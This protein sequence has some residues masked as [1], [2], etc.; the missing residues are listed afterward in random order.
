MNFNKFF[1]LAASKGITASQIQISKSSSTSV[2]LFK[3]EIESFKIS[4]SQS[5]IACGVYNGKMGF[6]RTEKFGKESFKYL[7]DGIIMTAS[8][9]EKPEE[10]DIFKGSDKYKKCSTYSKELAAVSINDKIALLKKVEAAIYDYDSRIDLVDHA[11]FVEQES[12]AEFY[13]SYGLKLKRR[14]NY[15][16]IMAGAVARQGEETKTYFDLHLGSKLDDFDMD[17]FVKTVCDGALKKFGGK[18]CH[19][20][21]YPTVVDRDV[22]ADL[23]DYFLSSAIA[24]QV[25][26]H[27]SMLEGKLDQK[28]ASGKLTIE[29]KPLTRNLFFSSFDD[30][31]VATQNKV[32]VKN[33]VLKQY[34][35]NR[36]TAK[37]DGVESTGNG[38]WGGAKITTAYSNVFVK[39]GK[40]SFDEMIA[41]IKEG[42]YITE[43]Q[44][45]GT[46][47]NA[48]SGDFSCQA[49]GYM[50]RDGKVAEPLTLITLSG[51]LLK[52]L[53]DLREFDN[54]AKMTV[55][56]ISV[57][58]A[59]IKSLNIG[60][61]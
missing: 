40:K 37:K 42:V 33:G 50:I 9:N 39:P 36:E 25:Q 11:T 38:A 24:D 6:A 30:E 31:G 35:Y 56:S 41:P 61:K 27:S 16:Y 43:V 14:G 55:G 48:N 21:K 7:V 26:R 58:D 52:M 49:E 20:K 5:L 59:Y 13:N 12:V 34:F 15:Y 10:A 22:M 19:T 47:M 32:I 17:E 53:G 60:G 4:D 57:A 45:L 51:N 2:T 3:R 54:R 1:E 44:G 28:I 29:E 18:P 46:G 8:Y 23:V